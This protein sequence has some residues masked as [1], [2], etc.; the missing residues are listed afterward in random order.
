MQSG[1]RVWS[2]GLLSVSR[3][4]VT[5]IVFSVSEDQQFDGFAYTI[6]SGEGH[7]LSVARRPTDVTGKVGFHPSPFGKLTVSSRTH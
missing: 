3:G 4:K 7:G 6:R 5:P 1:F 2:K